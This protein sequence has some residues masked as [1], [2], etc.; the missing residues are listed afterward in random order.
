VPLLRDLA[1]GDAAAISQADV[2]GALAR[3]FHQHQP[4]VYAFAYVRL[5]RNADL[6]ADATQATFAQALDRL[7][8]FDPERG[9]MAMWLCTLARNV[10]R[11]LLN[12]RRR[13]VQLESDDRCLEQTLLRAL[14]RINAQPL[15][16]AVLERQ[17][18]RELV[19]VTLAN[20]PSQYQAVLEAKYLRG[21]PL[22]AIAKQ[23]NT[24]LDSA[25]ATLRRARAAFRDYFLTLAGID[26]REV[27]VSDA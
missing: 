21:Q 23:R 7:A 19:S 3:W 4:G 1:A 24:T 14:R 18:T 22:E 25:K 12:Q 27:E 16:P 15:P 11:G 8:E 13:A 26:A 17:E 9:E 5:G 20:L 10:I 2:E 6:A